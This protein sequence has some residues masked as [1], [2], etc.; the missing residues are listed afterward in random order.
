MARAKTEVTQ[1]AAPPAPPDEGPEQ[2]LALEQRFEDLS[3]LL[4]DAQIGL[5]R[6]IT[7][8]RADNYPDLDEETR[9]VIASA[10]EKWRAEV[11][12]LKLERQA[13]PRKILS[14]K[15][16]AAQRE[17]DEAARLEQT[18]PDEIAAV[19]AELI[20]EDSVAARTEIEKKVKSLEGRRSNAIM[21]KSLVGD[22]ILRLKREQANL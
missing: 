3:G 5:H 4:R 7:K 17:L 8:T 10:I 12:R 18:L 6:E 13:L 16:A 9:M 2:I 15:I 14:L 20:E 1:P 19:K 11:E 22:E 21:T